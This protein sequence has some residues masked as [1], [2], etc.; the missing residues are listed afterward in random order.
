MYYMIHYRPFTV[1][2]WILLS[3]RSV[4]VGQSR[5][6]GQTT[7]KNNLKHCVK[8]VYVFWKTHGN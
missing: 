7:T 8:Y 6:D 4:Q 1:I 2:I 3:N 5:P